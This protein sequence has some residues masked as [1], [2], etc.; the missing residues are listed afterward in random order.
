MGRI[1]CFSEFDGYLEDL[2]KRGRIEGAI[3]DTNVIITLSY[4]AKKFH[5]SVSDFISN[6]ITKEKINLYSTINTKQEYL[7]F[8]R[9][10]LMTE[11]LRT[12]VRPESFFMAA[13]YEKVLKPDHL[14]MIYKKIATEIQKQSSHIP[15]EIRLKKM[16]LEKTE[17]RIHR[18]VEFIASAKAKA[19]ASI[20]TALEEAEGRAETLKTELGCLESCKKDVFEPPAQEWLAHKI[21]NIQGVLEQKT[22]KSALLLRKL[23]GKIT[24]TPKTPEVGRPYYHAKSRLKNFALLGQAEGSIW[25]K[26]RRTQDSNLRTPKGQR[27]SRPPLST[28]QPILRK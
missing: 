20:A 25:C 7:E 10:L 14:Q 4:P 18:F 28:T 11:G 8:H 23:T 24:L 5:N 22:E 19:T 27:F 17:T 1:V 15:E 2:K 21:D 12:I 16:E 13:L 9:R 26:W 3:L 6:K